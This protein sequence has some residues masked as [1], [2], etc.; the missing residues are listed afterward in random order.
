[1]NTEVT[2][3]FEELE[4]DIR[5]AY[6]EG[7]TIDQAERLAA[8]FLHAQMQVSAQLTAADLDA[9]MKKSGVKAIRAA[10]YLEEAKKGDKKPSDVMLE[11][12]INR[13]D[14]VTGEQQAFDEAEVSRDQL[15]H[16]MNVFKEAHIY[17]RG[18]SKG[19]FE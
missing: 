14:L 17:F 16:Y 10:I 9:R 3:V 5:N 1:M 19:R 6:E 11:A 15:Q 4:A 12:L 8:K 7:V 2:S 13:N 18:I